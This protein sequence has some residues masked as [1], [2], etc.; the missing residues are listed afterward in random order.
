MIYTKQLLARFISGSIDINK[1]R[2]DLTVKVCEVEEAHERIIPE[3]IVIWKVLEVKKHP[4]AD[5]LTVCQLDCWSHGHFQICTWATNIRENIYVPVALPGC[6][7]PAINLQIDPR[8]MRWLESN[9][10]ICSKEEL[11][12]NEDTGLHW[13]WILQDCAWAVTWDRLIDWDFVDITDKN[14]WTSLGVYAPRLE[15]RILDIENKTITQRPDLFWHWWIAWE[16]NAIFSDAVRFSRLPQ[17]AEQLQPAHLWT[18]LDH[19]KK[20]DRA[21]AIESPFVGSYAIIELTDIV[22]KESSFR[23]RLQIVDL[24]IGTKNNWIDFGTYFMYLTWQPIHCFD[25]DCVEWTITVRQAT[26]GEQFTDLFDWVH[27]LTEDDIVICDEKGILALAWIIGGKTS[28]ITEKTKKVTIEIAQF[29]PVVVRKTAMRL[30]LRTDAQTR[31]EKHIFPH[32]TMWAILLCLDELNYLWTTELGAWQLQWIATWVHENYQKPAKRAIEISEEYI[33]R[34]LGT[35]LS[36]AEMKTILERL[37]CSVNEEC[38]KVYLPIWR[39]TDDLLIQADI[40]EEIGRIYWFDAIEKQ[41]FSSL[42]N[43]V[44]FSHHIKTIRTIEDVVTGQLGYTQIETYPRIHARWHEVFAASEQTCIQMENSISPEQSLL[45]NTMIPHLLEVIEKNAPVYDSVLVYDFGAVWQKQLPHE[46]THLCLARF[47]EKTTDRK[48]DP[49]LLMKQDV[50]TLLSQ[51]FDTNALNRWHTTLSRAHTIQQT[52]L[53]LGDI[54]LWVITTLHPRLVDM[55]GIDS[56]SYSVVVAELDVLLLNQIVNKEH[57]EPVT[58][59]DQLIRREVSFVVQKQKPYGLITDA[60]QQLPDIKQCELFDIYQWSNLSPEEK[61]MSIRFCI[62][63]DGTMTTEQIND[64]MK[65]VI[66]AG[67]SAGGRLR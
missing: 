64:I 13:I 56:T 6:F 67:E 41:E 33:N 19:A 61:S 63:G 52:D 22:V 59:Q 3:L 25:G 27:M 39:W 26:N 17:I 34:L 55:I 7:L 24:G 66:Q 46:S 10:M 5:K 42:M 44:P 51:F 49:F 37:W 2:S 40:C 48:Q 28:G 4:D 36:R 8:T 58:L 11:W 57:A 54:A 18:T 23:Q 45:R 29:D 14:L 47:Q 15:N 50:M 32:A 30:G 60:I 62:H 12:I 31:Y 16:Y 20:T 43:S 1:L 53:F 35:S 9:G 21:I 65:Q 38:T